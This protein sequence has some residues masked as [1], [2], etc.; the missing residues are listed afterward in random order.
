[1]TPA[2]N[3]LP[4]PRG[5]D[6]RSRGA[7]AR[8]ALVALSFGVGAAGLLHLHGR[9]RVAAQ[10]AL[11]ATLAREISQLDTRLQ[12]MAAL[13][14]E[15]EAWAELQAS[16]D[17]AAR[18]LRALPQA[19]PEGVYLRSLAQEGELVTLRGVARSEPDLSALLRHLA[20]PRSGFQQP[21]LVEF[22]GAPVAAPGPG[23]TRAEAM[24]TDGAM[25]ARTTLFTVR[26]RLAPVP[27]A[28]ST[29]NPRGAPTSRT[30]PDL[31][32]AP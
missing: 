31:E 11:N 30:R 7:F 17:R 19:L 32:S 13:R 18:L 28:D 9:E 1:M 15:I 2:I 3:L 4:H 21:E 20:T 29:T 25:P 14:A 10:R 6:S 12:G 26:A 24:A 8:A 23:N 5:A 22:T 27:L 16:R